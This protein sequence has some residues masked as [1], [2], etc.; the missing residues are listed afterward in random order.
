MV[1]L[2]LHA[3]FVNPLTLVLQ[4]AFFSFVLSWRSFIKGKC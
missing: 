1:P 3:L 4:L 2:V